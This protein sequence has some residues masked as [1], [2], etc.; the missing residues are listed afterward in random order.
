[1]SAIPIPQQDDE[2]TDILRH[3]GAHAIPTGPVAGASGGAAIPTTPQT[4]AIP[5][6]EGQTPEPHPLHKQAGV[7][8]LW[9]KA[10]NIHNPV[11]RVLG[12]IGAGLARGIDVAGT[13][14]AP[15]VAAAI[16]GSTMNANMHSMAQQHQ[17]EE[18]TA[19]QEKQAVTAHTQ[20]QTAAI[21]AQTA[22]TE[23]E[24]AALENP[25]PKT[26]EEDWSVIPG[27]T[28]ANGEVFQQ[29]KTSG[30][31][32]PA[33]GISGVKPLK[34]PNTPDKDKDISDYLES[35]KLPDS[36]ANREKARSAIAQRGKQEP[37]SFMPL[38][39]TKT[40]AITGAWDAKS[41]RLVK[42]P[43]LPG[44][45]GGGAAIQN[46]AAGA[47]AKESKPYQDMVENAAQAH[48]LAEMAEK[49]NASA[50]VDLVLS[51]FKMMK[52]A[53]GQG[54]RFTQQEQNLIIGARSAG[55]GLVAIGQKV[56][57]EGQP[58]TPEQRKHM[59]AVM[60]MHAK[61][62]ELHLEHEGAG[63]QFGGTAP[64]KENDPLGIR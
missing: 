6:D 58:L 54:V 60:D 16:P 24:T 49:G 3:T 32:R 7:A 62:A 44:T 33:A 15:G 20:A 43:E 50:D 41:G 1:M 37:G 47:A 51:F 29:E 22:H 45:T 57:G 34:E 38:Y 53:G 55:Q 18:D 9:S 2:L 26:K 12:K 19:N 63:G 61:A 59:V 31:V 10:E 23:A 25:V 4:G 42:A 56:I 48:Q 21:P 64:A 35:H 5:T 13:V 14:I 17:T 27:I 46:R 28:G 40:G 36:P 11:L 8:S 52:G 39:D 30:Q